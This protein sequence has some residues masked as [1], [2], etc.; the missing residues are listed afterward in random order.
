MFGIGL[1][2][3]GMLSTLSVGLTIDAYGPIS[4]NAGGIAE[5]CS[6]GKF[7]REKTDALDS[8]GNTTAAIGKG[9]AIGSAAL[10]GMAL[11]GAFI[12]RTMYKN[13]LGAKRQ[14]R[15]PLCNEA[16]VIT[17]P[18]IFAGLIVGAM[19]PYAF[20]AMTMKSVGEAALEMVKEIRRQIKEKPGIK[21]GTV[22]PDYQSCIAIS[23]KASL[24]Q[25]IPPGILVMGTPI[26]LG[27]MLGPKVVAG[28]L[29][30]GIVSG[31]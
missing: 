12:T 18:L 30:G 2:A 15:Y 19:L 25:M 1:S 6:L 28:L 3:L 7:L 8:A 13:N 9:F 16:I 27:V 17:D 29:P 14:L 31:I 4:D 11:F 26:I 20:S 21:D 22:I 10:V 23:T 5:M 24:N